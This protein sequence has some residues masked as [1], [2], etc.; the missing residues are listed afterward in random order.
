M[1]A[2][3]LV[4]VAGLVAFGLMGCEDKKPTVDAPQGTPQAAPSSH[5]EAASKAAAAAG[6]AAAKTAEVAKEAAA[7]TA[8]VVKDAA[9]EAADKGAQVAKEAAAQAG[10]AAKAAWESA[11][12]AFVTDFTKSFDGFKAQ[13]AD[14]EKR[15]DALPALVKGPAQKLL[16]DVKAKIGDGQQLIDKLR[17]AGETEWKALA[18]KISAM[19]P[20]I[21]D[22]LAKASSMIPK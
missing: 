21:N 18:D 16:A 10:E 4:I 17:A 8:E 1:N 2:H 13:E 19:I 15:I 9:K 5:S 22:G 20:S 3:R 14:L 6:E 7:K 11:K 12:S